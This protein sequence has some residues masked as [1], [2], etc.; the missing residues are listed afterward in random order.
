M[1]AERAAEELSVVMP[2]YNEESVIATTV[3]QWCRLLRGAGVQFEMIVLDDGSTDRTPDLLSE[4]REPF[5]ELTVRSHP[6]MGHGPA[7]LRGYTESCAEWV[8]QIDSDGEVIP[9]DFPAFWRSRDSYDFLLG[10]RMGRNLSVARSGLSRMAG[11]SSRI[12]FG[13]RFRDVNC[14]FRLMRRPFLDSYLPLIPSTAFAPNVILSG[15][16][17]RDGWRTLELPVHW[18]PR[19]SGAGLQVSG[20][21][22]VGVLRSAFLLVRL[23]RARR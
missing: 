9:S 4:L 21:L 2:V 5:H 11:V 8:L 19:H 10:C 14:P 16:A 22:V 3:E 20:R 23:S 15:F 17:A 13:S 1:N 12:C 6:N 18:V 7:V